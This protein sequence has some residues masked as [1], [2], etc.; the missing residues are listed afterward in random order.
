[1]LRDSPGFVVQRVLAMIVNLA[2]D[3]AQQGI[4]SVEDIDQAVHLGLGYPHGPLEWGDRL[5]P[6]RL[7]SILQRL[8]ALPV[9]RAT[10]PVPGCADE[11]NW[12]CPCAPA[13]PPP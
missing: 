4:A 6:R 12:A 9:T 8:Q 1:M 3:I 13:K 2:C 10:G 11:R 7:L 5:G